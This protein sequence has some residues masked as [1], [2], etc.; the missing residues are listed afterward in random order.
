M[1][2]IEE[3][4]IDSTLQFSALITASSGELQTLFDFIALEASE[5]F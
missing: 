2:Q 4:V 5:R 3:K 1:T